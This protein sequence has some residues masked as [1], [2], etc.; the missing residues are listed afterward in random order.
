LAVATVIMVAISSAGVLS[1]QVSSILRNSNIE[2]VKFADV[3]LMKH[4]GYTYF[5]GT[6]KSNADVPLT[7]NVS[8]VGEDGKTVMTFPNTYIAPKGEVTLSTEGWAGG[9]FTVGSDYLVKVTQD[10]CT[11]MQT[12]CKGVE[13]SGGSLILL[14]IP[15]I[16]ESIPDPPSGGITTGHLTSDTQMTQMMNQGNKSFVTQDRIGS[17]SIGGFT[18]ELSLNNNTAYGGD[19]VTGEHVWPNDVEVPFTITYSRAT[20]YVWVGWRW[21]ET[22]PALNPALARVLLPMLLTLFRFTVVAVQGVTADCYVATIELHNNMLIPIGI[23]SAHAEVTD[24]AG[25]LVA[26]ALLP[27]AP[28]TVPARSSTN[29]TLTVNLAVPQRQ[30]NQYS[31][32]STCSVHV[33]MICELWGVKV[34]LDF[35]TTVTGADVLKILKEVGR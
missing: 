3:V 29:A 25:T 14:Q 15:G 17:N 31:S 34:P 1:N 27:N 33:Q 23:D 2:D 35:T 26:T 30:L 16:S 24:S 22:M 18:Y 20:R 13:I 19:M 12:N 4:Y 9:N 8:V 21:T 10:R 28:L 7:P 5:K 32:S 6:L 11:A